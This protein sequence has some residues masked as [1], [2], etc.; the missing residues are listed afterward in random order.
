MLLHMGAAF[1]RAW[2]CDGVSP[3]LRAAVLLGVLGLCVWQVPSVW[4]AASSAEVVLLTMEWRAMK[5]ALD[6]ADRP[7]RQ[8][9]EAAAAVDPELASVHALTLLMCFAIRA[10]S[11][12]VTDAALCLCSLV[13]VHQSGMLAAWN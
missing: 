12:V 9:S 10:V 6:T 2:R 3:W 7:D 1:M 11:S 5:A 13:L 4:L 8:S